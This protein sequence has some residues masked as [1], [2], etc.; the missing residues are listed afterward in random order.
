[1]SVSDKLMSVMPVQA[2]IQES[3]TAVL[4]FFFLDSRF[5]ENDARS[6]LASHVLRLTLYVSR[7]MFPVSC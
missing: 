6:V 5:R 4:E 1:M 7:L 2:G 3:H